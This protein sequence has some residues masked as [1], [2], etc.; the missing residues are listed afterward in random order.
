MYFGDEI[1]EDARRE[2]LDECDFVLRL[3]SAIIL[4]DSQE[5][6][7]KNVICLPRYMYLG[8]KENNGDFELE[9]KYIKSDLNI[10]SGYIFKESDWETIEGRYAFSLKAYY[11]SVLEDQ[12][13]ISLLNFKKSTFEQFFQCKFKIWS[14][15]PNPLKSYFFYPNITAL[16]IILY[17]FDN[18]ISFEDF[19]F[20]KKK[21]KNILKEEKISRNIINIPQSVR[22]KLNKIENN[23]CQ[24]FSDILMLPFFF[25]IGFDDRVTGFYSLIGDSFSNTKPS[26]EMMRFELPSTGQKSLDE[27]FTSPLRI[28]MPHMKS[29]TP[30]EYK[31]YIDKAKQN[32]KIK[33]DFDSNILSE[34]GIAV[35]Y[36]DANPE[37]FFGSVFTKFFPEH[38]WGFELTTEKIVDESDSII[39]KNIILNKSYP[40]RISYKR[41]YLVIRG[42]YPDLKNLTRTIIKLNKGW[43][44]F[45]DS[46]ITRKKEDGAL[47]LNET[48]FKLIYSPIRRV[49]K[50]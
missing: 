12:P 10:E 48:E 22:R 44:Q 34:V 5:M 41:P 28:F 40:V 50:I 21:Y 26:L 32:E 2:F 45:I 3:P 42:P 9:E 27:D 14:E 20:H 47:F 49:R 18:K 16:S 35:V 33:I 15:I 17:L 23:S 37:D 29:A 8:I 39:G 43:V 13:V 24:I 46:N 38:F 11:I 1:I 19:N 25:N 4:N 36:L 6:L 31:E 7:V 30:E